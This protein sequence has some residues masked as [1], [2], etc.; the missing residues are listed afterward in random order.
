[1]SNKINKAKARSKEAERILKPNINYPIDPRLDTEIPVDAF[2][3]KNERI[4]AGL[5]F[6]VVIVPLIIAGFLGLV[7][8]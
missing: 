1:M 7:S 4:I 3:T 6:I 2:V 8:K 5:I